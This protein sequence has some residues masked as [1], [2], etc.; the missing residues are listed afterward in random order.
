MTMLEQ[1]VNELATHDKNILEYLFEDD[2]KGTSEIEKESSESDEYQIKYISLRIKYSK[3]LQV[4]DVVNVQ[5]QSK[6]VQGA[7][8]RSRNSCNSGANSKKL[9]RIVNLLRKISCNI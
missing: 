1:K 8:R 5:S 4:V 7:S 6:I 2:L 3:R 9:T